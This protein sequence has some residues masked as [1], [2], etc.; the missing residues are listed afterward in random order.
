MRAGGS[1]I[2]SVL[3]RTSAYPRTETHLAQ[4]RLS[5]AGL[6]IGAVLLAALLLVSELRDFLSTE[7]ATKVRRRVDAREG[8]PTHGGVWRSSAWTR[9]AARRSFK[10]CSTSRFRRCR[11]AVSLA[12]SRASAWL[13]QPLSVV[14][15]LDA[16]DL[17]GAHEWDAGTGITRVRGLRR[18]PARLGLTRASQSRLDA[19]GKDVGPFVMAA[20]QPDFAAFFGAANAQACARCLLWQVRLR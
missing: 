15:Q 7:N 19:R 5:G 8:R 6:S 4:Q 1:R 13:T 20:G 17:A 3:A 16:L 10:S 2:A 11:V 14:V 9:S 12:R 18:W